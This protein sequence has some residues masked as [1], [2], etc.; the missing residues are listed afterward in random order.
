MHQLWD[1]K[2][3]QCSMHSMSCYVSFYELKWLFWE[4]L[5]QQRALLLPKKE[6]YR[7]IK[8]QEKKKKKILEGAFG[9]IWC[10]FQLQAGLT[11]ELEWVASSSWVLKSSRNSD[12]TPFLDT[13]HSKSMWNFKICLMLSRN[14]WRTLK[15]KHVILHLLVLRPEFTHVTTTNLY[16]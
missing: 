1:C 8:S 9:S 3:G 16:G 14:T 11:S 15:K 12:Y 13:F 5:V 7:V 2:T 4:C 10:N 6:S